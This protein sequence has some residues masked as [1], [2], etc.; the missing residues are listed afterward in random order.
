VRHLGAASAILLLSLRAVAAPEAPA[1]STPAASVVLRFSTE[2]AGPFL[3]GSSS[4]GVDVSDPAIL[5]PLL[6]DRRLSDLAGG[7]A[8]AFL[9]PIEPETYARTERPAGG[10]RFVFGYALSA[11]A[12]CAEL[13]DA[14]VAFDFDGDRHFL[15][16][17]LLT[18]DNPPLFSVEGNVV[19]GNEF[20]AK[21]D[22]LR[23][24]H[25]KKFSEGWIIQVLD[26]K[27]DDYCS[28]V[29]PPYR[30][31]TR[32]EIFGDVGTAE[33]ERK[34]NSF[35]KRREFRCVE[36]AAD[37]AAADKSLRFVL[38]PDPKATWQETDD[39]AQAHQRLATEAQRGIFTISRVVLGN[40]GPGLR[41]WIESMHFRF[42]LRPRGAL[43]Q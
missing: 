11:C 5:G 26:D 20:A 9:R 4:A 12:T 14:R 21:I 22:A 8:G 18:V 2:G 15:A 6:G 40:L 33:V 17:R 38:W 16:A 35:G 41:P 43:A 30:G 13:A 37:Y 29:T 24:F 34:A 19:R 7:Q 36:N 27:G 32:L 1:A 25:L 3:I 10:P 39:N 28:V 42:E 31:T 23:T